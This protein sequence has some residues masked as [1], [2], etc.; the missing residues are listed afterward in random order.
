V[1]NHLDWLALAFGQHARAPMLTTI[2]GF[3]GAGIL[4]AYTRSRSA[5]V[6]ISASDHYAGLDYAATIHRG[7]DLAAETPGVYL[8]NVTPVR[9]AGNHEELAHELVRSSSG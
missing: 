6:A 4:P 1:H 8:L 2:H 7:I 3:S 9:T 5:F